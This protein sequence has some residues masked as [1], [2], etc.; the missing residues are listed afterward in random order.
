MRIE[1]R[2]ILGLVATGIFVLAALGDGQAQQA[3]TTL[4]IRGAT[5]IDGISDARK[6]F[7]SRSKMI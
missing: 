5:I 1:R 2:A 6:D 7:T 3:P 4:L